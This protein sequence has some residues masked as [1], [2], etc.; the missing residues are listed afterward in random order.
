M[1]YYDK[2]DKKVKI[3]GYLTH[4]EMEQKNDLPT[5]G[6]DVGMV[7]VVDPIVDNIGGLMI[8]LIKGGV[9]SSSRTDK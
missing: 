5:V 7:L 3:K 1:S 6:V 2:M 8:G 9:C 4:N